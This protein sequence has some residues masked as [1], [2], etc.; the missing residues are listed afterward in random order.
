MGR[1]AYAAAAALMGAALLVGPSGSTTTR[2]RPPEPPGVGQDLSAMARARQ[3]G[4]PVEDTASGSANREVFAHPDGT[5]SARIHARP[6]RART[7]AGWVPIDTTLGR[8][9][10]GRVAPR[11]TTVDLTLSGGGTGDL[12]VLR[13][14]TG[15]ELALSWPQP[16]PP[17]VLT[18]DTARYPDVIPGV[19]LLMHATAAGFSE[20]LVV[21]TAEAARRPELARI[22]FG[23]RT[24]GLTVRTDPAG[25]AV[26]V[27]ADGTPAVT[28]GTAWMWDSS[29]ARRRAATT[30]VSGRA[31]RA[32][33]V[34]S[35][36]REPALGDR[37][38]RMG[39]RVE[40]DSLTI[41]PD[42]RLLTDPR[43]TFPVYLDPPQSADRQHWLMVE[44]DLSYYGWWDSAYDARV[45]RDPEDST[46]DRFRS[47]FQLDT[48]YLADKQIK[49]AI[50]TLKEKWR[51][52]C[53]P[54]PV[55]LWTSAPIAATGSWDAKP[56]LLRNLG[57][58]KTPSGD[59]ETLET[60]EFDLHPLVTE[61]AAAHLPQVTLA[62]ASDESS[63]GN[64]GKV[65]DNDPFVDVWYN[66]LP[67]A[68][69]QVSTARV[70]GCS[71]TTPVYVDT[72]R[73]EF[74]VRLFDADAG[75]SIFTRF[76]WREAGSSSI[77]SADSDAHASGQEV[78]V[79]V[80]TALEQDRVYEWRASAYNNE[81]EGV[82]DVGPASPWC[83]F[84]V[85]TTAPTGKPTVTRVC[86]GACPTT[87]KV[88]QPAQFRLDAR[89]MP[90]VVALAYALKDR[91]ATT[92]PAV[93]GQ[94]TITV[95][96]VKTLD[97]LRV[98]GVDRAGN[99]SQYTDFSVLATGLPVEAA[100]WPVDRTD[101]GVLAD[102]RTANPITLRGGYSWR[103][104]QSGGDAIA[105]DGADGTGGQTP[106]PVVHTNTSFTVT[107]WVRL[108][109]SADWRVAV[110]QSGMNFA[111][112]ELR[113]DVTNRWAFVMRTSDTEAGTEDVALSNTLAQVAVW[114]HLAGVYDHEAGELRIYVDGR[115]AGQAPHRSTWD[116]AGPFVVGYRNWYGFTP[117]R[118]QGLLDD[119]H[120]YPYAA[121]SRRVA[122]ITGAFGRWGPTAWWPLDGTDSDATSGQHTL[123]RI[124]ATGWTTRR[125]GTDALTLDGVAA[126]AY[127]AN[128]VVH[129]D[130]SFS[131]AAWVRLDR[132]A[133]AVAVSQDGQVD[134]GFVL[135]YRAGVGWIFGRKRADSAADTVPSDVAAYRVPPQLGV[136]L[137]LAGVYDHDRRQLSLYVNGRLA[138]TAGHEATWDARG[139]FAL[140]RGRL[141]GRDVYWPGALDEVH[142]VGVATGADQVREWMASDVPYGAR[143]TWDLDDIAAGATRRDATGNG[144]TLFVASGVSTK[145]GKRGSALAFPG[146]AG[147]AAWTAG[148][149]ARTNTGFTVAAWVKLDRLDRPATAVSQDGEA[150]SGF[151][152]G[153][154]ATSQRWEFAMSKE[155]GPTRPGGSTVVRSTQSPVAQTWTHLAATYDGLKHEIKLYVNGELVGTVT[156]TSTWTATG[157][158]VIGRAMAGGGPVNWLPG[159][160]DEARIIDRTSAPEEIRDL[161]DA[162][163]LGPGA[164]WSLNA[165]TG[166][167]ASD[168]SGN[169]FPLALVGGASWTTGRCANALQLDGHTGGATA[170][171]PVLR[172]DQSFT[173]AAW[174]RLDGAGGDF[175]AMSQDGLLASSFYLGY[176]VRLN[177]WW[178]ILPTADS[179]NPED[180]VAFSTGP[181]RS[182]VWTH[183]AGVY[184]ATAHV[185]R[186]YVNGV[187]STAT[188]VSAS[189]DAV[190]MTRIGAAQWNGN[191]VDHWPGLI[192]D[193]RALA[194][195]SS[196]ADVQ[197]IMAGCPGG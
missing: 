122:E 58:V 71:A 42:R 129:T 13:T 188:A 165:G 43:T 154:D 47:Y 171:G 155:D 2:S 180:V 139:S 138:A 187:P 119:L 11:A 158:A 46:T 136:W 149:V 172:T 181:A 53:S 168:D 147:A 157:P 130:A 114:T 99:R 10:D 189:W 95:T 85:D 170:P 100:G 86:V 81:F 163:I 79:P 15:A 28:F 97:T 67:A 115:L 150:A 70:A 45:G 96:P 156:H 40:R 93:D 186:L 63:G 151:S 33:P 106:G 20:V 60:V 49:K 59:C 35:R 19:D 16:L 110:S 32:E 111:G 52:S 159:A 90:D 1:L 145:A 184:D 57:S 4:R 196:Q 137:H 94:A 176:N 66:S 54:E 38:A 74:R 191:L 185:M 126:Q 72:P 12:A 162:T 73:P 182:G 23:L 91:S 104:G 75:Q 109:A 164:W 39:L 30:G 175:A 36:E 26:A 118:W 128:P 27:T 169:G 17:P 124:G 61:A 133:T 62:I 29:G 125:Q 50:F 153:Y 22:R 193:A 7:G 18:A 113:Y 134:S 190:G 108:D 197:A 76:E 135:G 112:M 21:R 25:T 103:E 179:A 160:V 98:Y 83:R 68:P 14:A 194:R 127:T 78:A 64:G 55:F 144:H 89:A 92:V 173:V 101:T 80:S 140:G 69:T 9:P 174:V 148:P 87:F 77:S 142:A 131:V 116:A 48:G 121:S 24:A 105:L 166:V 44:Q 177:K 123:A 120:V 107:A 192:D 65:F 161:L 37:R 5:Y 56:A 152:L 31:G 3:T 143:A 88:D 102:T 132:D 167:N 6:V 117:S 41:V 51:Y 195:A 183:L 178:F 146:T 82:V 141:G 8:R 34:V 84:V